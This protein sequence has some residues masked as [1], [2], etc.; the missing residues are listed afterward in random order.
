MNNLPLKKRRL[1]KYI[2]QHAKAERFCDLENY[3]LCNMVKIKDSISNTLF[4]RNSFAEY[5]FTAFIYIRIYYQLISYQ[6]EHIPTFSK[7][8]KTTQIKKS[9]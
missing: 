7:V 9:L 3:S 6:V 4:K 1:L 2:A 5:L 8:I